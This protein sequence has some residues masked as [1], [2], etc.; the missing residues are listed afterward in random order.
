MTCVIIWIMYVSIDFLRLYK[1]TYTFIGGLL[2]HDYNDFFVYGQITFWIIWIIFPPYGSTN[3]TAHLKTLS[4]CSPD[5]GM[6][7]MTKSLGGG[8]PT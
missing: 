8:V 4:V 7:S 6:C 1:R 5:Y 3:R 2:H